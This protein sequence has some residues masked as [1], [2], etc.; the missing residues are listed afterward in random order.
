MISLIKSILGGIFIGI[1]G[2]VYLST[3]STFIGAVLFTIGLFAILNW[4]LNLFTGKICYLFD[5]KNY[6]E[7]TIT[8]LG[9]FIGTF[10]VALLVRLTRLDIVNKAVSMCQ[11]KLNDNVL[12]LFILAI[13]C[14]ILIYLAVEGF[15]T[16][17]G[18]SKFLALFFGVIVFI[19]CGFEHCIA[20]MFYF[21]LTLNFSFEI[22]L[23]L[24]IIILGNTI[25]G[26][27]IR[28]LVN[29]S[30]KDEI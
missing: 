29:W 25:G 17:K 4:N 9:N 19:M 5:N 7:C 18:F 24:F 28:L 26:I 20:D 16:F 10:I 12:S 14:N 22:L 11:I 15:K 1:G 13:L 30:R 21:S 3:S 8:L 27:G 23:R 6:K 2:V